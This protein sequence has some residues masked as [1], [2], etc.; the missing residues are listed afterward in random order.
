MQGIFIPRKFISYSCLTV[1]LMLGSLLQAAIFGRIQGVVH[2]PQHRP[3]TG[4][5]VKLEA[6]NSDFSQT[7]QT[8]ANGEF[9]FPTVPVGDYKITVTPV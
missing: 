7:A 3:I 4:A 8:D 5:S 9:A 6:V 2:D 1:S